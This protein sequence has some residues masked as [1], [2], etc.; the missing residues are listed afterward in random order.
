MLRDGD[1]VVFGNSCS[2]LV[3]QFRA[4]LNLEGKQEGKPV[5]FTPSPELFTPTP[6]PVTIKTKEISAASDS[7][8]GGKSVASLLTPSPEKQSSRTPFAAARRRQR[9]RELRANSAVEPN[10]DVL[11]VDDSS[12]NLSL[13]WA[14]QQAQEKQQPQRAL[15]ASPRRLRQQAVHRQ[16]SSELCFDDSDSDH[17]VASGAPAA[18]VAMDVEPQEVVA[19]DSREAGAGCE[20]AARRTRDLGLVWHRI[21]KPKRSV[22]GRN[23]RA[24]AAAANSDPNLPK[25]PLTSYMMFVQDER[26]KVRQEHPEA[27]FGELSKLVGQRWKALSAK[28]KKTWQDKREEAV[29][30]YETAVVAY[31]L[32]RQSESA[33]GE[34]AGEDDVG[35][36]KSSAKKRKRMQATPSPSS[37]KQ[38][39]GRATTKEQDEGKYG[40]NGEQSESMGNSQGGRSA[41]LD[42][43]EDYLGSWEAVEERT[44]LPRA[45]KAA[46]HQPPPGSDA[47]ED[48]VKHRR[49]PS[50]Q[51]APPRAKVQEGITRHE[52]SPAV[53]RQPPRPR[54]RKVSLSA[55]LS[56]MTGFNAASPEAGQKLL[57][58]A[59]V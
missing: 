10:P 22:K 40:D 36:R 31:D 39:R 56:Q 3:Y 12:R 4:P 30:V 20:P 5:V 9:Q 23:G 18:P 26:P 33:S 51:H 15:P 1:V 24:A 34:A 58:A 57:L 14:K 19:E 41:W 35:I 13:G 21:H 59:C 52:A 46:E 49:R 8:R 43:D 48:E 11:Q 6:E 38:R 27:T 32:Q 45:A 55:V 29:H 17:G 42:E 37:Q 53:E 47:S 16:L 2:S 28:E 25:K 7:G 44:P 54:P 50:H